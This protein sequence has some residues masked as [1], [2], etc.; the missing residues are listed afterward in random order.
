MAKCTRNI[1]CPSLK[2]NQDIA[3]DDMFI[4]HTKVIF[5]ELYQNALSYLYTGSP[6]IGAKPFPVFGF[7]YPIFQYQKRQ[8]ELDLVF[9]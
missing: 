4:V 2:L 1:T 3:G 7:D 8:A 5:Q 6:F 9:H